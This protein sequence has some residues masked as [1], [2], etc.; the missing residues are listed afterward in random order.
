MIFSRFSKNTSLKLKVLLSLC[1]IISAAFFISGFVTYKWHVRIAREEINGQFAQTID[2]MM[3]S[4]DQKVQSS[5]KLSNQMIFHPMIIEV[6]QRDIVSYYDNLAL[7][8]I[9]DQMMLSEPQLLSIHLFDLKGRQYR[10][11]DSFLYQPLD[12]DAYGTIADRLQETEGEL[13][14]FRMPFGQLLSSTAL[15]G[16]AI[17][18]ARWMKTRKLETYGTLIFVLHQ[19]YFMNELQGTMDNDNSGLTLFNGN[20]ELLYT[21]SLSDYD[22]G[23]EDAKS[24]VYAE[25]QSDLTGFR[26]SGW[27]SL[28][29]LKDK[30][31]IILRISLYSGMASVLLSGMLLMI[32]MQGLFR[33]LGRLVYGM[34]RVRAGHMDTR[35][36]VETR[37]ELAFL[38]ESFN[39]MIGN[40]N[41]LIKE[42]YEKQ[43]RERE[44][45]LKALQ[46][47]LNPHFLYNTLDMLHWR[48]FLQDDHDNAQLVVALSSMLRY[49]LEPAGGETA[50]KD[51]LQQ[52]HNYLSIQRTRFED[53]LQVEIDAAA[54][55]LDCR[56]IPLLLQPLVENIFVHA[57]AQESAR[58]NRVSIRIYR[59][60]RTLCAEIADN[61]IGIAQDMV[62]ELLDTETSSL[63]EASSME[64][65]RHLG[66]HSV[67]RRIELYY[68]APYGLDIQSRPGEGTVMTLHLP[69][70]L[71]EGDGER[72][73]QE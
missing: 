25:S 15:D 51:E 72:M 67:V 57:F 18:A 36:Q 71:L 65:E 39:S 68:G 62:T 49:S 73:G 54:D 66:V 10:P 43:L 44:A 59:R 31:G 1:I 48:L 45:E 3:Y 33:P 8:E 55:V 41:E 47:Q 30:S 69:Y 63:T 12:E 16:D 2:Q 22:E 28:Q 34:R 24:Y 40:I 52:I 5:Y 29:Q 7:Q 56:I 6:L 42:V 17:I 20:E 35:I 64:S 37:D 32:V 61:G 23:R 60:E 58:D 9:L 27:S 50:V 46:A 4:I 19:R 26:L 11:A 13:V 53:T 14:W 70:R 21:N 38:G